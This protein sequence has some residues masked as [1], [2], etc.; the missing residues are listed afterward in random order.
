MNASLEVI[1][2]PVSDH[3]KSPDFY[4]DRLGFTLDVDYAPSEDFRVVQL[5]PRG[6]RVSVQFGGS[7]SGPTRSAAPLVLTKERRMP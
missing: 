1:V 5:T 7:I 2:L 4:R 3:D 6:S